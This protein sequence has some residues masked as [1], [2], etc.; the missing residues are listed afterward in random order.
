MKRTI[1][2]I[3]TRRFMATNF[4][5]YTSFISVG[6]FKVVVN[7]STYAPVAGNM[8]SCLSALDIG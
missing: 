1:T 3:P 8:F 2:I 7:Q 6:I 4:F 5:F